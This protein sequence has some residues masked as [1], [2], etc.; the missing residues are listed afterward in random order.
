MIVTNNLDCGH[1]QTRNKNSQSHNE[2][3]IYTIIKQKANWQ[4][5]FTLSPVFQQH[6]RLLMASEKSFSSHVHFSQQS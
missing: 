1:Y 5:S 2:S 4:S 6:Q 3:I